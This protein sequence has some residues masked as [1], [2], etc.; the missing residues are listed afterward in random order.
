MERILFFF[1]KEFHRDFHD[2][3]ELYHFIGLPG[4][5]VT[6]RKI[7]D[8]L[9]IARL[10]C[11]PDELA[12]LELGPTNGEEGRSALTSN[13][14]ELS[15]PATG[16]SN[17]AKESNSEKMTKPLNSMQDNDARHKAAEAE[18]LAGK[19]ITSIGTNQYYLISPLSN[20]IC[21]FLNTAAN[22]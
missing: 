20:H 5:N 3:L 6:V 2:K 17:E 13:S 11:L 22:Y 16:S 7:N 18:E 10:S 8:A 19:V 9:K 1:R 21:I 14:D 4:K 12:K 15:E